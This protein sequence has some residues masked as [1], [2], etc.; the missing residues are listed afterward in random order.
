M[1]QGAPGHCNILPPFRLPHESPA[2]PLG[3]Q[4]VRQG[5]QPGAGSCSLKLSCERPV[6]QHADL[7]NHP[8]ERAL[9]REG[10]LRCSLCY[11]S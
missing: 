1:P 3:R 5:R 8:E 6:T 9:R 11:C 7:G 2:R 10:G 4:R